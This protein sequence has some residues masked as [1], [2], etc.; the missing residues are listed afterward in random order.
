MKL[1]SQF[2]CNLLSPECASVELNFVV[3]QM[4]SVHQLCSLKVM[5]TMSLGAAGCLP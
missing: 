5:K 4:L 2:L 3:D 1:C